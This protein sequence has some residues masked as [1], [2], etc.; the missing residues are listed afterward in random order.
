MAKFASKPGLVVDAHV[1]TEAEKV[2]EVR[3]ENGND[4]CRT[5][6][7]LVTH[8]GVPYIVRAGLFEALFGDASEQQE[9]PAK[10]KGGQHESPAAPSK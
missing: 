5:G 6:D 1:V 10:G 7:A 8:K 4:T 2:L 3:L 9:R